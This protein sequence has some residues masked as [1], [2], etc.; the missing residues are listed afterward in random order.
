MTLPS[1]T[2]LDS[3]DYAFQAQPYVSVPAK[4]GVNL[5]TMDYAFQAQPFV[6]NQYPTTQSITIQHT[7]L[8]TITS[9][10]ST[11][12]G[13][14]YSICKGTQVQQVLSYSVVASKRSQ[15]SLVY[16]V[17]TIVLVAVQDGT[18]IDLTWSE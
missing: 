8:Y 3:M 10:K 14:T 1:S 12:K 9:I 7:L 16:V 18:H 5:G 6:S 4:A 13:L 2:D 11:T 15:I 17:T